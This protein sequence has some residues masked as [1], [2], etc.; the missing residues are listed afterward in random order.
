MFRCA[1]STRTVWCCS[2]LGKDIRRWVRSVAASGFEMLRQDPDHVIQPLAC[3][4]APEKIECPRHRWAWPNTLPNAG[5]AALRGM[6]VLNRLLKKIFPQEFFNS[7]VRHM[8]GCAHGESIAYAI[9]SPV[10]PSVKRLSALHVLKR[11]IAVPS[12]V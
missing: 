4:F 6:P 11:R 2:P 1:F 8:S 3:G 9:V 5:S 12:V 7:H 10:Q